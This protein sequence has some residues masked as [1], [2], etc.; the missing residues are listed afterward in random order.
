MGCFYLY[1]PCQEAWPALS[2]ENIQR[3]TKRRKWMKLGTLYRG[4]G[5]HCCRGVG[6]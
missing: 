3:G 6:M 5:L 2:E 4:E 1:C